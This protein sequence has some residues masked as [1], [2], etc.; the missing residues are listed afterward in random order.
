MLAIGK[1]SHIE[2]A[3][4]L[5]ETMA[6]SKKED[7]LSQCSK[8]LR[9]LGSESTEMG[10]ILSMVASYI[11]GASHYEKLMRRDAERKVE[12]QAK[13]IEALTEQLRSVTQNASS[14]GTNG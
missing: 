12:E 5:L 9:Y 10:Q 14:F 1:S 11:D 4:K 6:T 3:N 8:I 7:H 13:Q 2:L